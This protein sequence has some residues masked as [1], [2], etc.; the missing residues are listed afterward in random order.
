MFVDA[1]LPGALERLRRMLLELARTRDPETLPTQVV[2]RL[3]QAPEVTVA[4]IWLGRPP[5]VRAIG[6]SGDLAL[7]AGLHGLAEAGG[8]VERVMAAGK[9]HQARIERTAGIDNPQWM[10]DARLRGMALAP[11]LGRE[12]P[13][14]ILAVYTWRPFD[15][16]ALDTLQVVADHIAAALD[17]GRAFAEIERLKRALEEE[18]A[19]LKTEVDDVARWGGLIGQSEAL[20]RVI[21]RIDVVAGTDATVLIHGESGVGKELV[22]REIHR[23]SDRAEQPLVRVNCASIPAE[24]FE[25]EFF[26]HVRGAFTGATRDRLGRFAAA[27]GGT[28]FLDEVGEIPLALQGKLL[29]VLQEG[30]YERVGEERTRTVD[31]RIVAATN[32]DLRVEVDAGRFRRDLFYRL[33]VF[34]IEVAPLRERIADIEPLARSFAER[35]AKRF[36]VPR[37]TLDQDAIDALASCRWPGNVRELRNVVERAVL[38]ARGGPLRFDALSRRPA[39]ADPPVDAQRVYSDDEMNRLVRENLERALSKA[40]GRIYGA[41]G[42]AALLG[43]PATTLASRLKAMGLR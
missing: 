23:R 10:I 29:R 11:L 28:L 20:A 35:A 1:H 19:L 17:A 37:P 4:C 6:G 15:P 42:A 13:L 22:A 39:A 33:D 40:D 16:L 8:I 43:V 31:A 41:D 27:D 5:E 36:N 3:A 38:A 30:Q 24:L 25:S 7:A 34:P 26:G 12:G 21:E 9:P 14:G 32:R 18:N 2:D